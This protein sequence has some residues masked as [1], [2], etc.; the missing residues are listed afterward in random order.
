MED[1][2]KRQRKTRAG[3]KG[4]KGQSSRKY[5]S[6]SLSFKVAYL[7]NV[8]V[9]ELYISQNLGFSNFQN[10][11]PGLE[12]GVTHAPELDVPLFK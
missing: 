2:Y 9:Y 1:I 4:S 8:I 3:N 7:K 11:G 12:C 5:L 10:S 6:V